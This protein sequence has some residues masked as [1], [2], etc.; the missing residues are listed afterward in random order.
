MKFCRNS[1]E[2]IIKICKKWY[3]NSLPLAKESAVLAK[4]HRDTDNRQNTKIDPNSRFSDL[5]DSVEF[6]RMHLHKEKLHLSPPTT[7]VIFEFLKKS[8]LPDFTDVICNFQICS[9]DIFMFKNR[10][11]GQ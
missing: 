2:F 9:F 1:I 10:D 4:H 8:I 3:L 5:S 7:S 11:K 6:Y